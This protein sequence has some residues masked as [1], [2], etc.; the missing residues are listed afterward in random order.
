ARRP[1]REPA[2][3]HDLGSMDV[4]C[5]ECKALH[6]SAERLSTSTASQPKFGICCDSGQ[7]KLPALRDPPPALRTL[8][9]ADTDQAKEFRDNIWKYNRTFAFTSIHVNEDHSINNGRGP[10]V[11]RIFGEL[12]HRGGPLEPEPGQCPTYAQH[13][14]YDP[15]EAL[16]NRVRLNGGLNPET[17]SLLQNI[18]LQHNTYVDTYRHAHEVMNAQLSNAEAESNS[19]RVSVFLRALEAPGVHRRRGN[20]PT[21]SEVAVI[22]CDSNGETPSCRDVALHLRGGGLQ[23]INDLHPSYTP[24][25]YVVLFPYGEPGW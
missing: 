4:E 23:I 12:Y 22:I 14:I 5:P 19:E 2:E 16:D 25:Q 18:I 20:L 9:C 7:V 15:Q 8:F 17:L 3:R 13:Y 10:P 1:Y 24:L 11:F 21:A 6:W